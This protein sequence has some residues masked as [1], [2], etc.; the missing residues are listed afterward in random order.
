MILLTNTK[1]LY[2]IITLA[3]PKSMDYVHI[4]STPKHQAYVHIH[5]VS[6]LLFK[7]VNLTVDFSPFKPYVDQYY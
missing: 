1:T 4:Y 5:S 3:R 6:F 2:N 7:E